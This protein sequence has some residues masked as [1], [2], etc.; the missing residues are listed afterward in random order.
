M[1]K[2]LGSAAAFAPAKPLGGQGRLHRRERSFARRPGD[3]VPVLVKLCDPLHIL[4]RAPVRLRL[5]PDFCGQS[6]RAAGRS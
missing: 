1:R 4:P 6:H 2:L 5:Q 3:G